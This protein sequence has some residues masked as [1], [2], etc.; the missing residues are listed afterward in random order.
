MPGGRIQESLAERSGVL[1]DWME[2]M[3]PARLGHLLKRSPRRPHS[4]WFCVG[5]DKT[6]LSCGEL[7]D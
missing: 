6:V 3:C 7:H 2:P 1:A 4:L 5:P